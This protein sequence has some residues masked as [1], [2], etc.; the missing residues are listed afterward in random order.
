MYPIPRLDPETGRVRANPH[1]GIGSGVDWHFV[2]NHENSICRTGRTCLVIPGLLQHAGY[3]E[4]TWL[5]R[6]LPESEEDKRTID[7]NSPR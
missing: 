1:L 3:K 2:R 5:Q 7:G 4:S 6:E